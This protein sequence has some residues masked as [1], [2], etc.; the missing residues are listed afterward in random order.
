MNKINLLCIPYSGGSKYSFA[1]LLK[2][3]P[4]FLNPVVL[5]LPGRGA[6]AREKLLDDIKKIELDVFER[7]LKLINGPYA[8]YGHSMGGLLAYLLAR[9]IILNRLNKPLHLFITGTTGPSVGYRHSYHNLEKKEFLEVIRNLKG[10]PD[11]ILDNA[12]IMDFF[13]PVMRADFKAAETYSYRASGLLDVPIS[14]IIGDEEEMKYEDVEAWKNESSIG[15][16]ITKL[17]GNHFFIFDH[18]EYIMKFIGD[19]IQNSIVTRI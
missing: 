14:V 6:R 18:G 15:V 3:T 2:F 16:E 4:D 1:P 9:N 8:I 5:E 19:K 10:M 7:A 12:E 13:E 11:E 17:P